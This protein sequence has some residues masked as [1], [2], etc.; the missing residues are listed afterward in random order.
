MGAAPATPY[1]LPYVPFQALPADVIV[2]Y[3]RG[4]IVNVDGAKQKAL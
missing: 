2:G 4:R 1:P 3:C